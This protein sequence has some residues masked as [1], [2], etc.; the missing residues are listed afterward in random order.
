MVVG[1]NSSRTLALLTAVGAAAAVFT[2]V[3]FVVRSPDP[4]VD[5]EP[6]VMTVE[7]S[8]PAPAPPPQPLPAAPTREFDDPDDRFDD[9]DGQIAPHPRG[10][11]DAVS[12]THLTLPTILRV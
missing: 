6:V 9:D 11:V 2:L 12:Y 3:F 10:G 5:P 7:P 8:T 4:E 1:M